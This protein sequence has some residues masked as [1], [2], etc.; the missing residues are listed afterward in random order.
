MNSSF[1]NRSFAYSTSP[2]FVFGNFSTLTKLLFFMRYRT[3]DFELLC[4]RTLT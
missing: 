4:F 1:S 3:S 2:Q